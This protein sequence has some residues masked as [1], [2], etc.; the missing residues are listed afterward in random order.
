MTTL[1]REQTISRHWF[2]RNARREERRL[3]EGLNITSG[4]S[5]ETRFSALRDQGLPSWARGVRVEKEN[6]TLGR[7]RVVVTEIKGH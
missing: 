2:R 4:M 3:Q 5:G 6:R 1:S 7:W